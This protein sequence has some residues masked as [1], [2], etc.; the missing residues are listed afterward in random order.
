M[1]RQRTTRLSAKG[2]SDLAKWVQEQK[3]GINNKMERLLSEL[4]D[5]GIFEA[6]IYNTDPELSGYIFFAKEWRAGEMIFIA[7]Q[8]SRLTQYWWH[9]G[10]IAEETIDPLLMV[11]FGSGQHAMSG[12][13]FSK[14]TN[15]VSK[16]GTGRGTLVPNFGHAW[17]DSWFFTP[18]YGDNAGRTQVSSGTTPKRP[19]YQAYLAMCAEV[20][21]VA[22]R[23]FV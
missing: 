7:A 6:Q 3:D 19:V 10:E 12:A 20:H 15:W 1:K 17:E 13:D 14:S 8:R 4:A 9:H 18:V 21:R 5:V 11:E 2:F 16:T 22:K 23:V